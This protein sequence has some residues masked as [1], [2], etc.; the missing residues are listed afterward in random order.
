MID[1]QLV[2]F[3]QKLTSIRLECVLFVLLLGDNTSKQVV[4]KKLVDG[5][6]QT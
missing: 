3:G 1:R 6:G 2:L 4:S 5:S